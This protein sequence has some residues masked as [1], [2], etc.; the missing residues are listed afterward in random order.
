[1]YDIVSCGNFE[2]IYENI[3]INNNNVFKNLKKIVS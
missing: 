2:I 1:M 3:Q